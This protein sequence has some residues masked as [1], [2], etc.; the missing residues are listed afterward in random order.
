MIAIVRI[1]LIAGFTSLNHATGR[2][3]FFSSRPPERMLAPCP[4]TGP[5]MR[6]PVDVKAHFCS[7][8]SVSLSQ[9]AKPPLSPS[10]HPHSFASD[11]RSVH[12]GC[13]R[14]SRCCYLISVL[15][16]HLFGRSRAPGP[17]RS[18]LDSAVELGCF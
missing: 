8:L 17:S 2:R 10:F 14:F 6:R 1:P 13:S 12:G 11:I 18:H 7:L 16:S 4:C 5:S 9:S 15:S 3:R